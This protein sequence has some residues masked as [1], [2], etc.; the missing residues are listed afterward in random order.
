MGGRVPLHCTANG[1]VLL[2]PS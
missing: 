1:K 2:I